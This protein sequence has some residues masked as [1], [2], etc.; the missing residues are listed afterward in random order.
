M[1]NQHLLSISIALQR[2]LRLHLLLHLRLPLLLLR[3]LA[4]PF[5]DGRQSMTRN[6]S[7][8]SRMPEV[9]ILGKPLVNDFIVTLTAAKLAGTG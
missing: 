2:I 5:E 7:A 9:D 4:I 6:S 3:A 1:M 8:S